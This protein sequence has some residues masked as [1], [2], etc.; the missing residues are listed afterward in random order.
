MPTEKFYNQTQSIRQYYKFNDVDVDRYNINGEYTQTFLSPREIDESK[1]NQTWLN[2]HL[3][4]THGYGVTLSR[5]NAVTASGQP[6]MI[7]KNIPSESSA[8]EVQVKRPQIY[9]GELTNDY[10]VTETKE[11]EFDYPDGD[12]NKYSRYNGKGGA[13]RFV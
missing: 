8:P 9:Y 13:I 10:A 1:I 6:S 11:D 3:K 5:V 2:K 12:S 7:V 4:Y